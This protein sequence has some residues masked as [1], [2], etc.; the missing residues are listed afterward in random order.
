MAWVNDLEPETSDT[1][2]LKLL[3]SDRPNKFWL[4]ASRGQFVACMTVGR[5]QAAA[6]T[7]R[8]AINELREAVKQHR[9]HY[10]DGPASAQPYPVPPDIE[11]QDARQ[12]CV[13]SLASILKQGQNGFWRLAPEAM[14][15]TRQG[16][17]RQAT[18]KSGLQCL[19]RPSAT[20]GR[21]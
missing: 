16:T 6:A 11:Q 10:S 5:L 2:M 12:R 20:F 21:R 19:R 7:P 3:H 9:T 8:A 1:R 14:E 4:F 13:L 18:K 17:Q 15:V